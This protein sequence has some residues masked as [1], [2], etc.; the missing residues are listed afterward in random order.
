METR[1]VTPPS[2][3]KASA[4][5][6]HRNQRDRRA[7]QETVWKARQLIAEVTWQRLLRNVKR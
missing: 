3:R 5:L 2:V 4:D 6:R 7:L 1:D